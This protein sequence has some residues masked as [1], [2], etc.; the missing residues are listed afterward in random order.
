MVPVVAFK[1]LEKRD[2]GF[3]GEREDTLFER[4]RLFER[5]WYIECAVFAFFHI[6]S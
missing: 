1:L 5:E 4:S 2:A 6:A 3:L